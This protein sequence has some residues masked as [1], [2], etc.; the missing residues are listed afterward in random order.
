MNSYSLIINGQK[1]TTTIKS[2]DI[3][4]RVVEVNGVD[5]E[6]EIEGEKELFV[7]KK[8]NIESSKTTK[9]TSSQTVTQSTS[10]ISAGVNDV[11]SP[12]P[13]LIIDVI[14]KEGDKVSVGTLILKME[15]M[16]MENE[17]KSTKSGT[18]KKIHVKKGDSVLEGQPLVTVE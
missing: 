6:V 18:V 12:I 13:G 16:K 10:T 7:T 2:S 17:I 3:G 9:T 5:Y 14:V 11:V 15:A 4:K 1:F 8:A